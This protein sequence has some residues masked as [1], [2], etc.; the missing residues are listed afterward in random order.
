M[1]TGNIKDWEKFTPY[2]TA[3]LQQALRYLAAAQTATLANGEYKIDGDQ[4]FVRVNTYAT[5]PVQQK[6]WEAHD[7]YIDVQ[8]LGSGR[9]R[10]YYAAK[11]GQTMTE[12]HLKDKDV[13]FYGAG[14]AVKADGY[15]DLSAG[16]FA[17]FYPWELHQPGCQLEGAAPVQKLVVKVRAF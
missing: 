11:A 17:V 16:T 3:G 5:E 2:L 9:E 14:A 10:I 8:F 1:L 6:K 7:A 15:V 4:V 13:A 12:D